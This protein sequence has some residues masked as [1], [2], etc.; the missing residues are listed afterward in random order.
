MSM[1]TLIYQFQYSHYCEK[2]RWALDHK[3]VSYGIK[4]LLPGLHRLALRGKVKDTS[5]PVLRMKGDYIQGSDHIIDFLDRTISTNMLTPGDPGQLAEAKNWETFAANQLATPFSAFY[6]SIMLESPELFRQRLTQN[7]PWYASPYYAMTFT[8][9]CQR[10]RELYQINSGSAEI[11]RAKI[12]AGLKKLELHLKD[13]SYL[14]G[15][16]FSRADLSVAALLSPVAVPLHPA[17]T[18]STIS[19]PALTELRTQFA[20]SPVIQWVRQLYKAHRNQDVG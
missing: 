15:N 12:E 1:E 10:I 7:S 13:R 6:Y 20:T 14:V 5:L 11:A 18:I 2:A 17:V 19:P 8:R 9:I 16:Q 4:N 3:S